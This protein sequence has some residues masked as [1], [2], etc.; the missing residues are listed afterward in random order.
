MRYSFL[1]IVLSLLIAGCTG[2]HTDNV[3]P[4]PPAPKS[5]IL[6]FPAQNAVCVSGAVVSQ[7]NSTI[8][9]HWN[10]GG[11][12]DSYT[13]VVKNLLTGD[14]LATAA[15]GNSA[16][17]TVSRNTPYSW[18]V[19]SK[20][21]QS[22]STAKSETWK[23]YNSG[24]GITTY[25]PFPADNLSPAMGRIITVP[26]SAGITLSWQGG[27]VDNDIVDYD[28]YF[29]TT[30][31]TPLYKSHIKS[32]TISNVSVN[33]S[34]TYYWKIVTRDSNNNTSTSDVAEFKTN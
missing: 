34:T 33:P 6:V 28:L 8:Q 7:L 22:S 5:A 12:S 10:D 24:D 15:A 11:N 27:S 4:T 21:N 25:A 3:S 14:T 30:A 9:F 1:L 2:K 31:S 32:P 26:S 17:V 23:F 19:V 13:V 20:S 29:G 16:D 18:Y